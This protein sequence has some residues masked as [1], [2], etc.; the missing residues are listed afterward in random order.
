MARTAARAGHGTCPTAAHC[1][2]ACRLAPARTRACVS[3]RVFACPGAFARSLGTAASSGGCATP[4]DIKTLTA[5]AKRQSHLFPAWLQTELKTDHAGEYGAVEIYRGALLGARLRETFGWTGADTNRMISFCQH[6]MSAE[7][8]HLEVMLQLVPPAARTKLQ[9]IWW[10]SARGLGFFPA[11]AGPRALYW[12]VMAVETFVEE[13]YQD[14]IVRLEKDGELGELRHLF[15]L[16]CADEVDHRKDA[17]KQLFGHADA[18]QAR[19]PGYLVKAWCLVV[20]LGS[21]AAVAASK[22]V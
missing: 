4:E 21:R 16:L 5:A 1:W 10:W 18:P 3:G 15:E 20:D 9:T 7:Q 14:Q 11:L 22:V 8:M 17:V 6:H 13:H 19:N 12:T 2:Y